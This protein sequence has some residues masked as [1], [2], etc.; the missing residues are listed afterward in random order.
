MNDAIELGCGC[1][2]LV[3]GPCAVEDGA[4]C[5][6]CHDALDR[7]CWALWGWFWLLGGRKSWC[8]LEEL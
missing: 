2:A 6:V 8:D 4:A 7:L 5:L 1:E 3:P